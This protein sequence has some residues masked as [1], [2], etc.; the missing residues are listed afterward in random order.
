MMTTSRYYELDHLLDLGIYN[1]KRE[2]VKLAAKQRD[3]LFYGNSCDVKKDITRYI[4]ILHDLEDE[5]QLQLSGGGCLTR[6]EAECYLTRNIVLFEEGDRADLQI[7]RSG[8]DLW[9]ALNP[10]QVPRQKWEEAACGVACEY[11]LELKVDYKEC[12]YELETTAETKKLD[13]DIEADFVA[14]HKKCDLD[15]EIKALSFE[16]QCAMEFDIIRN[17]RKCEIG[18]ELY[19]KTNDCD[20]D[21]DAYINMRRCD[22]GM[23]IIRT[24]LSS[25]CTVQ[26]QIAVT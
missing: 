12:T 1:V 24:V 5:R 19:R 17:D 26:T 25:G 8:Y 3:K 21:L 14:A 11:E 4:N 16:E 20:L 2:L 6:E 22:L 9:V 23:N 15:M 10:D 7:D 13:C 18:F